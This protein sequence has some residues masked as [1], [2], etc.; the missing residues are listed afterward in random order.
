MMNSQPVLMPHQSMHVHSDAR[1]I[2]P[3]PGAH[4]QRLCIHMVL[5]QCLP[6]EQRCLT[7]HSSMSIRGWRRKQLSH[8]SQRRLR[9]STLTKPVQIGSKNN[10]P[11]AIVTTLNIQ[12]Y[13]KR[14]RVVSKFG[15]MPVPCQQTTCSFTYSRPHYSSFRHI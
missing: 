5:K 15:P 2:R 7:Q 4:F 8:R 14:E 12:P 1:V 10:V 6:I 9:D 11:V 13:L 3:S